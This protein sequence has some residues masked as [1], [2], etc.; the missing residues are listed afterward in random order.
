MFIIRKRRRLIFLFL[1]Q[2]KEFLS[3]WMTWMVF[4]F[5]ASNTGAYF[6]QFKLF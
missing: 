6:C 4:M 1:N 3:V 5:G 2:K